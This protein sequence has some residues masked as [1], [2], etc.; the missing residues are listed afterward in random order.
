MELPPEVPKGTTVLPLKSQLS[1]NVSMMC[2]ASYH[3]MGKPTKTVSY[4]AQDESFS[5]ILGREA[6]S[7]I[8]IVERLFLSIQSRSLAV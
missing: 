5:A 1:K 6:L 7:C 2:G 3:Q 8:S 4:C